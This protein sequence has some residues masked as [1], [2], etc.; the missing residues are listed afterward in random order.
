LVAAPIDVLKSDGFGGASARAIA[1]KAGCNQA[2]IFY[3]FGTVVDLLLAALDE[4]SAL[5]QGRYGEA[6]AQVHSPA[7]LLD[8]AAEIFREDIDAGHVTVLVEMIAGASSIPG[9]GP[10]VAERIEPWK[11]FASNA[12]TDAFGQGSLAS[13]VPAE[14][15]AHAIVALYLGLEMLAHLDGDRGSAIALFERA[16]SIAGLFS[17]LGSAAPPQ[18][19]REERP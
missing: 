4:V 7:E 19:R 5:R 14:E 6:L 1:E 10:R 18:R 16:K 9:L 13:V 11:Q 17:L 12:I 2:L 3:H 15:A 8:A